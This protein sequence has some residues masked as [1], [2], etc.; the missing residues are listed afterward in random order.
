MG[1]VTGS[2]FMR[3]ATEY[4]DKKLGQDPSEDTHV[5]SKNAFPFSAALGRVSWGASCKRE[6]NHMLARQRLRDKVRRR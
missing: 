6:S 5:S 2:W 1:K 4:Y 3:K